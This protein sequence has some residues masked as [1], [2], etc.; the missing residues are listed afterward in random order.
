MDDLARPA[1]NFAVGEGFS[2]TLVFDEASVRRIASEIGDTNPLHH[3]AAFARGT[4]FGGLI[5]S[6]GHTVAVMLGPIAD[7]TSERGGAMGLEFGFRLRRAVH[8]GA[9]LELN[10]WIDAITPKDS[11]K[12][13]LLDMVGTLSGP[14][15]V[16]V[17]AT[18]RG[19]ALWP[20]G[21]AG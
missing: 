5:A 21:L 1:C 14:E 6:G 12:G 16:A 13:Y 7:W 19:V 4:R 11:L 8:V 2:R 17:E 18:C 3:D 10:W 9:R 15:G 20:D